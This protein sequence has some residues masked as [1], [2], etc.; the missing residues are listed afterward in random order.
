[1]ISDPFIRAAVLAGAVSLGIT[2]MLALA[3]VVMRW[4]LARDTVRWQRFVDR[5]RP[6]LLEATLV[7]PGQLALPVLERA[8]RLRCLRLWMYVHESVRGVGRERLASLARSLGLDRTARR[9]L[10]CRSRVGRLQAVLACGL[11]RDAQAWD[12]LFSLSR[13]RDPMLSVCAA[14]ALV[15]ID[16]A[17]AIPHLL[18]AVTRR[19]DWDPAMVVGVVAEARA[20]WE[21]ALVP[22]LPR[23]PAHEL[24]RA[25]RLAAALKLDLTPQVQS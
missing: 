25:L 16:P 10:A 4:R 24:P 6:T 5:W 11:L 7:E 2:V 1:V 17:R 23:V 15:R 13:D 14:R 21:A 12:R 20:P 22:A 8:D 9:R 19:A 18:P 3:I